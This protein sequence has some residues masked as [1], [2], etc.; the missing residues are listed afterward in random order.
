[1]RNFRRFVFSCCAWAQMLALLTICAAAARA[2]TVQIIQTNGDQ[3]LL[4]ATQPG[5]S[6]SSK[7][8][9]NRLTI[10]IN[11][12]TKYQQ[13]DGFGAAFTDSS[14]WLIY[15]KLTS[16][17][18]STLMTNLFSPSAGVGLTFG[19]LPMGGTDF[20]L[21]NYT[22]DDMPAGQTDPNLTNFS[23]SHDTKYIIPVI[24]QALS[25]NPNLKIEALPWSPPAW[26]KATGTL[27]GGGFLTQYWS[28][29]ANY[30]VKFIQTYATYK[31]PIAYITPQNEPLNSTASYPS[32]SLAAT[33]EATFI[34]T[35]LGPALASAG[36]N[37]STQTLV[38][39]HNWQGYSYPNTV[40]ANTAAY[41]YSAGT[42]F[43]CYSGTVSEQ[44]KVQQ[45]YPNKG[46]WFTECS[47]GAWATNFGNNL[48]WNM[49][50]LLVGSVRDYA[51]GV[52]L[53]NMALDQNSGPQNG[54]CTNCRGVVTINDS[55]SPST[56]AY[57]VE[58][59]SLGQASKFFQPG[60]YRVD[61][62]NPSSSLIDVTFLNPDGT[63]E[64]MVCNTGSSSATFQVEWN[65]AA[66]TYTLPSKS[67]AT[68]KW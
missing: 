50:N 64:L 45:A 7:I 35:Y 54:G 40:L 13:M 29:L 34:G 37:T 41:N 67:V 55:V 68:F 57:N 12:G 21:G 19:R 24:Q 44:L 20:S 17:Q 62:N 31:I 52:L 38:F 22:Y 51:K 53:W 6:F 3:S 56:I 65:N 14:C 32:E 23:I 18:R 58:Y 43:H 26:M 5:I 25:L 60:A 28:S 36:L 1:M 10:K 27:D 66:F 15:N 42:F 46:I 47:G 9:N 30:F 33:D 39:E 48:V 2:Q 11:D 4:L 59:Y 63:H 61:S 49:Q 16:T 8:T